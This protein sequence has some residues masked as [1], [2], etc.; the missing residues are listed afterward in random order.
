MLTVGAYATPLFLVN[1]FFEHLE[2]FTKLFCQVCQLSTHH[3]WK[4]QAF[5]WLILFELVL[6]SVKKKYICNGSLKRMHFDQMLSRLRSLNM[7]TL[8]HVSPGYFVWCICVRYICFC[9]MA[10]R[11][12]PFS[13]HHCQSTSAVLLHALASQN[14]FGKMYYTSSK[15]HNHVSLLNIFSQIFFRRWL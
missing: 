8:Y 10:Y 3:F 7:G 2:I 14:I 15:I 5:D 11:L 1:W 9:V 12:G 13:L 6:D 4:E